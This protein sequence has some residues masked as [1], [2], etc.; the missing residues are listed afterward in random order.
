MVVG[1]E[2]KNVKEKKTRFFTGLVGVRSVSSFKKFTDI[3]S[4]TLQQWLASDERVKNHWVDMKGKKKEEL[5]SFLDV[6]ARQE[7]PL[8]A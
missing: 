6:L 4:L 5:D 8:E 1:C 2:K 7:A 3:S